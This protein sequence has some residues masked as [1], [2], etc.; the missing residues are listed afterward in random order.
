M[1]D[2]QKSGEIVVG[3]EALVIAMLGWVKHLK[4]A[5]EEEDTQGAV[6]W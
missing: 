1:I 5:E 3:M 6:L 4:E 2:R